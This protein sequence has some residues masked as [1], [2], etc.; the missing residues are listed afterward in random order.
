MLTPRMRIF[1]VAA[2]LTCLT[3]TATARVVSYAPYTDRIATPSYHRRDT[4]QF[5]LVESLS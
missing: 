3:L 2:V 4:T 1:A 5:A